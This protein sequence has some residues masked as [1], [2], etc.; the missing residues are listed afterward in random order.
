M[1]AVLVGLLL[2]VSQ[3]SCTSPSAG[4]TFKE[5]GDQAAA[6][7]LHNYYLNGQWKPYPTATTSANHDWGADSL[8]YSL[9]FRYFLTKDE[10][11]PPL[12]LA[13]SNTM[14][15]PPPPCLKASD[16]K[17]WSDEYL[18]DSV[19]G[20]RE[21]EVTH[22]ALALSKAIS[23]FEYVD[24]STVFT[25]GACPGIRYQRPDHS[26]K[27]LK[28]AETDT[29]YIR[30]AL[31]LYQHTNN[32]EYLEKAIAVY[33]AVRGGY[34]DKGGSNLYS[35]YV[36]DMD[37]VCAQVLG[38]YY[39]SIN[40]NMIYSGMKLQQL[41]GDG[42]YFFQANATASDISSV[43][44]DGRGVHVDLQAENDIVEPLIEAFYSL[45]TE[46]GE[47]F[48]KEWILRNAAGTQKGVLMILLSVWL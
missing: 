33:N 28:T 18:W 23:A 45:W 7:L 12:L 2:L 17:A 43:L 3:C 1:L 13:L 36:F 31:A 29:N 38:R 8:T 26:S 16:C 10:S 47:P 14:N 48:A 5:Y 30:A 46:Y 20:S 9:Y 21:F 24:N 25:G 34:L 35:V 19:A 39:S 32:S 42:V 4:A 27:G 15:S 37:G 40:G 44:A 41:T 11:I 6:A 22:A